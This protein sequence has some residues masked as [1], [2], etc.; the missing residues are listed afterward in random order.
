MLNSE[1]NTIQGTESM[2]ELM[3]SIY[4]RDWPPIM[5]LKGLIT[6]NIFY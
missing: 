4:S 2:H 6:A 5:E 3:L 1:I